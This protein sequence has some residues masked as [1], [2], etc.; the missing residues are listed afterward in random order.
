MSEISWVTFI[1]IGFAGSFV[2]ALLLVIFKVYKPSSSSN[3]FISVSISSLVLK[4]DL[5]ITN[6]AGVDNS[7]A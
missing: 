3:V 6:P 5:L 1:S 4:L 7:K 2:H